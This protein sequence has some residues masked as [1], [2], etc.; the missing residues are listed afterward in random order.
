METWA[1]FD[2]LKEAYR[3]DWTRRLVDALQ[4]GWVSGLREA[5]TVLGASI[6]GLTLGERARIDVALRSKLGTGLTEAMRAT[7]DEVKGIV[8]RGTVDD[9]DEFRLLQ[10]WVDMI[11]GDPKQEPELDA[12]NTLMEKY[13][14]TGGE[15]GS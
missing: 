7:A 11:S 2:P 6:Q 8:K 9:D 13:L 14:G 5:A 12:I 10:V 4:M 3:A 15:E 1:E